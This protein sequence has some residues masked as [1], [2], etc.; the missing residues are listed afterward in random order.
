MLLKPNGI[1]PPG[2]RGLLAFASQ[3]PLL[4][5]DILYFRLNVPLLL[6]GLRAV[7]LR[8]LLCSLVGTFAMSIFR[9]PFRD[10]FIKAAGRAGGY[11]SRS[12]SNRV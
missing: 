8:F 6:R 3:K 12:G 1:L 11:S 5:F 4:P 2:L 10:G 7:G 9:R